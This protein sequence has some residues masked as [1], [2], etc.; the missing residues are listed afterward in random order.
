[1]MRIFINIYIFVIFFFWF[2]IIAINIVYRLPRCWK[3]K[4]YL[5]K[6]TYLNTIVLNQ[7]IIAITYIL[8][9]L[10]LLVC[11]IINVR[12]YKNYYL[13]LY[14]YS[15]KNL[16]LFSFSVCLFVIAIGYLLYKLKVNDSFYY[17][18]FL[19]LP[20]DRY[21][22]FTLSILRFFIPRINIAHI[23]RISEKMMY[24]RKY[25]VYTL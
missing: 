14:Y 1:M 8:I 25:F 13:D 4:N 11:R 17:L 6:N 22:R 23:I 10:Y 12:L 5:I 18:H 24:K 3:T 16:I 21:E 20:Y 19:L 9:I 7:A 15:N 2:S